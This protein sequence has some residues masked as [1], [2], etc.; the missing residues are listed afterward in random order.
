M[1]RIVLDFRDGCLRVLKSADGAS[2]RTVLVRAFPS[3]GSPDAREALA[4]ALREMNTKRAAAAIILPQEIV[5]TK[6]LSLPAMETPDMMKVAGRELGRE[7]SGQPFSFGIRVLS[8]HRQGARD[9]LAEYSLAAE[10]KPYCDL[11]SSCGLKP[12]IVTSG[13][14]GIS[15]IF[16]QS[17]PEHTGPEAVVEIGADTIEIV[18]FSRGMVAEYRKIGLGRGHD[19]KTGSGE[20]AE[21]Q[22]SRIKIFSVVDTIYNFVLE[23]GKSSPDERLSSL[24][25]S[26]LGSAASGLDVSM[27]EGLGIKCGILSPAGDAAVF[28]AAA[29]VALIAEGEP[30]ADLSLPS[31]A[32]RSAGSLSQRLVPAAIVCYLILLVL[33]GLLL[34]R[35]E[36]RLQE[37]YSRA[38]VAQQKF[39]KRSG[40]RARSEADAAGTLVGNRP[41]YPVFRDLANLLP[42]PITVERIEIE[43][44]DSRTVLTITARAPAEANT[45]RNSMLSGFVSSLATSERLRRSGEPELSLSPDGQEKGSVAI[46][47]SYEVLP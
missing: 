23:Y 8:E 7:I 38:T 4:S 41:L 46:R 20:I 33:G 47:A 17:R 19:Q 21:D 39:A 18:V 5:R 11:A 6:T 30:F 10:V 42:A 31:V 9:L 24:W 22:A 35:S 45:F 36:Q 37:A 1:N 29:G 27:F 28:S 25:L 14:E 16:R 26:G 3:P 40:D 32:G 44:T 43:R 13:L 15:R 34:S 12:S 2:A